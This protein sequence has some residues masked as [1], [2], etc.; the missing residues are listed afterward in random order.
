MCLECFE[1]WT[2]IHL[3][4]KDKFF[5]VPRHYDPEPYEKSTPYAVMNEEDQN[6]VTNYATECYGDENYDFYFEGIDVICREQNIEDFGRQWSTENTSGT[7]HEGGEVFYC[8]VH[9]PVAK[10]RE[11]VPKKYQ[12]L[13]RCDGEENSYKYNGVEVKKPSCV[14]KQTHKLNFE[15]VAKDINER[16]REKFKTKFIVFFN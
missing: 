10:L 8:W 5:F 6:I 7:N 11:M 4:G 15:C 1:N 14:W 13:F 16:K 9:E 2:R 12:F 3:V